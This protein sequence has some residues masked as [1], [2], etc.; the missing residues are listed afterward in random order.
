MTYYDMHSHLLPQ[1]DDGSKSVE[2]SLELINKLCNQNV[3]NICFTPH[4]YS[5]EES[6]HDFIRNRQKSMDK[7]LPKLPKDV[8]VCIGAEVYVTRYLF[9]NSDLSP[10][11]YGNSDYILCEFGFDAHF[12]EHTMGHFNRLVN[13]YGL[14]PV[15]THIERYR[16]LMNN[17][18]LIEEVLDCGVIIQTNIEAFNNFSLRRKLIKYIKKGYIHILGT[19]CHSLTRGN[20]DDYL[21]VIDLIK[22]KC[23][24]QYVNNIVSNSKKIF[25]AYT[26]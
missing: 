12:Q 3:N 22:N 8:N 7:L 21:K 18:R 17:P 24:E 26:A 9:N 2:L 6:I 10:L 4:Y 14:K 15:L 13:N 23:G 20:P 1:L 11:C 19:D 5:N 16:N 25:N